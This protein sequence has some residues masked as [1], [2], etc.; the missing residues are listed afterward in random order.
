MVQYL[1]S[2]CEV[3]GLILKHHKRKEKKFPGRII[4]REEGR[5]EGKEE[6][7]QG[8]ERRKGESVR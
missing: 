4:E 7:N 6:E 8:K 2:M 5:E 1:S 3:L